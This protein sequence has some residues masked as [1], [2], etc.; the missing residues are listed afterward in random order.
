MRGDVEMWEADA[1]QRYVQRVVE[2]WKI[3]ARWD[4]VSEPTA[5]LMTGNTLDA[6]HL[7]DRMKLVARMDY[8]E[9]VL[10]H[11]RTVD[12]LL[13]FPVAATPKERA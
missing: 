8:A 6:P 2:Q 5:Y 1:M 7:Y 12:R 9:V 11:Q 13:A 10:D 3:E 4:V